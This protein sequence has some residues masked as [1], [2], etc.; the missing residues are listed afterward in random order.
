MVSAGV[1]RTCVVSDVGDLYTWGATSAKGT[2]A[3][4]KFCNCS[5]RVNCS[6]I[7]ITANYLSGILGLGSGLYQPIPKLIGG[8]KRAVSVAAGSDYT[9]VLTSATVPAMPFNDAQSETLSS[10][11]VN[12]LTRGKNA[13]GSLVVIP[14]SKGSASRSGLTTYGVMDHKSPS[15]ESSDTSDQES[16]SEDDNNE[17]DAESESEEEEEE[18]DSESDEDQESIDDD[19]ADPMGS[20][21]NNASIKRDAKP[22]KE[23]ITGISYVTCLH[24]LRIM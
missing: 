9:L 13:K 12:A 19:V 16:S 3:C 4:R 20:D 14:G 15:S 23:V 17:E 2:Y 7:Q 1:D 5:M 11:M 22:S 6:F 8:I 10:A 21:I 24:V 18:E